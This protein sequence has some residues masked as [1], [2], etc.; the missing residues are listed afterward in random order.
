MDGSLALLLKA[1]EKVTELLKLRDTRKNLLF[2]DV[3]K[4]IY[5]K[6]QPAADDYYQFFTSCEVALDTSGRPYH[7]NKMLN[8]RRNKMKMARRELVALAE[9]LYGSTKDPL[10]IEFGWAVIEIFTVEVR[11]EGAS[12][13]IAELASRGL[14]MLRRSRDMRSDDIE[15]C[16][17][18]E[19]TLRYRLRDAKKSIAMNW[20]RAASAYA[21]LSLQAASRG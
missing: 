13:R 2:N 5:E 11:A 8:D 18:D 9:T 19:E 10:V 3:V 15:A 12:S 20:E 16:Y 1:C 14:S 21:Q 6:L 7:T 17:S 4:P